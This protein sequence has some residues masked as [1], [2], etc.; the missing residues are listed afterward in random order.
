MALKK[1]CVVL[2]LYIQLKALLMSMLTE[3]PPL[4][5]ALDLSKAFD[6]MNHFA[7]FIKLINRN[8]PVNLLAVI[9]KWF[10][11]SVTCVK[12]S[13]RMPF[14]LI[15][16]QEYDNWCIISITIRYMCG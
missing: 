14:F 16:C 9:E 15:W 10:A 11:I 7:L 3:D 5:C 4:M 1:A 13:N 12:W 2:M 6:R 8:T